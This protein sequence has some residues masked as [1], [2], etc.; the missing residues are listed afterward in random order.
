LLAAFDV[1]GYLGQ[2]ASPK[3]ASFGDTYLCNPGSGISQLPNTITYL[4]TDLPVQYVGD[5]AKLAADW[6]VI[7]F[8][9]FRIPWT[10]AWDSELQS[11][12]ADHGKGLLAIMDYEGI[13]KVNDFNMMTAI[14]DGG[15]IKFEPLNL[16]WAAASTNVVLDC[17]P[18]LDH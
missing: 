6:D 15:G 4:G 2:V 5:P 14:T 18:D 11:F 16:P 13:V 8:C 10:H 1:L 7:L 3:V 17:V 12:V 9:G